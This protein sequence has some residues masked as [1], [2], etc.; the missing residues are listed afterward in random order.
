VPSTQTKEKVATSQVKKKRKKERKQSDCTTCARGF[1]VSPSSKVFVPNSNFVFHLNSC[2]TPAMPN[3]PP[4]THQSSSS[5][6]E[7]SASSQHSSPPRTSG[8]YSPQQIAADDVHYLISPEDIMQGREHR[9]TVMI[10]NIPNKYYL[11]SLSQFSLAPLTPLR[12]S[13]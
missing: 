11:V 6:T 8:R 3:S 5:D 12:C 2:S 10:R 13:L 1:S 9:T 4:H 7:T